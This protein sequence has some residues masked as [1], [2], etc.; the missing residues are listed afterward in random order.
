MHNQR[1]IHD[2][3]RSFSFASNPRFIFH[4][5]PGFE[6]GD[7]RQLKEVQ[8]FLKERAKS[9]EVHDQLHAIWSV[10]YPCYVVRVLIYYYRFC[11][12]PNVARPLLDLEKRFFN[13]KRAGNGTLNLFFVSSFPTI[14]NAVPVI[15][16]FTKFDD[17]IKQVYKRNLKL[18]ENRRA[19]LEAL[20]TKFQTPLRKFKFPPSAY[21]RLES[22][23]RVLLSRLPVH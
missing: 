21:V 9:T 15:A 13:E 3:H 5:S 14:R 8:S 2:I 6:T 23:F 17:L 18:N 20:E 19:A 7:E 1:G 22:M 10:R 16:I 11:F 12:E 4:D